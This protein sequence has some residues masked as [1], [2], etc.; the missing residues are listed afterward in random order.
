MCIQP[1]KAFS[2][3]HIFAHFCGKWNSIFSLTLYFRACTGLR[4]MR[5]NM[6]CAKMSTFTVYIDPEHGHD[7]TSPFTNFSMSS[8]RPCGVACHE[9]GHEG[10]VTCY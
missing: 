10:E 4:E 3:H 8:L 6:Y 7:D 5:E 1:L 9:S 2:R